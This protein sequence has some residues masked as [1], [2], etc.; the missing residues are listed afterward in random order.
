MQESLFPRKA[1]VETTTISDGVIEINGGYMG[2]TT[3]GITVEGNFSVTGGLQ[4]NNGN[5]SATYNSVA[6][7]VADTGLAPGQIVKTI[8]YFADWVDDDSIQPAGGNLYEIVNP[9]TGTADGGSYIDLD[10]GAQAKGLFPNGVYVTQFGSTNGVSSDTGVVTAAITYVYN[11]LS[12]PYGGEVIIP[13]THKVK[14]LSNI[15]VLQNVRLVGEYTYN[16]RTDR[17]Q[18]DKQGSTIILRDTASLVLQNGSSVRNLVIYREG[19]TFP[20]SGLTQT[21]VG[22]YAGT[23][24]Y[25][26]S[27]GIYIGY[28]T[29]LGFEWAIDTNTTNTPRGRVEFFNADCTNGI[30]IDNDFGGW[31]LNNCF[32]QPILSSGDANNIRSGYGIRILNRSDW[33]NITNCFSFQDTGLS[34]ENSNQIRVISSGFDHPTDSENSTNTYATG[35][36]IEIL[37]TSTDNFF[38]GCQTASHEIGFTVNIDDGLTVHMTECHV[39]ALNSQTGINYNIL[40]GNV[41][42]TGGHI[43]QNLL[44]ESGDGGTG[45]LVNNANSRV[46]IDGGVFIDQVGTA[47]NSTAYAELVTG[48]S[49]TYNNIATANRVNGALKTIASASSI[50]PPNGEPAFEITGTTNVQTISGDEPLFRQVTLINTSGLT[51]ENSAN[52]ILAGGSNFVAGASSSLTVMHMGGGVWR[53]TARAAQ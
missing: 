25:V 27:A 13:R 9:G 33:T 23:A 14:I 48:E 52:L 44:Y 29:V 4:T 40:G 10:N 11:N 30:R 42:I 36:G 49:V 3:G 35:T 20:S 26:N 7:M 37:G 51:Y 8:D 39:W 47:I 53:E 46:V 18:W 5:I 22:D 43:G 16:D 38:V 28:C 15:S 19:M 6:D 32:M 1:V 17:D 31:T 34:I 41:Y 21:E 24:I 2:S 12:D 45:V 50:T